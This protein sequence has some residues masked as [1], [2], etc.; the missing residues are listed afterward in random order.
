MIDFK[1]N[2]DENVFGDWDMNFEIPEEEVFSGILYV[3]DQ[4]LVFH[5]KYE[6]QLKAKPIEQIMGLTNVK[7]EYEGENVFCFDRSEIEK[8]SISKTSFEIYVK[9]DGQYKF[10]SGKVALNK[11]LVESLKNGQSENIFAA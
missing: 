9:D 11:E 7:I 5:V 10:N 1:F 4:R 2:D 6:N 3:T 8:Y